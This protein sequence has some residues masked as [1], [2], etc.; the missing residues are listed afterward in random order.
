M[1]GWVGGG[2]MNLYLVR[3]DSLGDTLWTRTYGSDSVEF[4]GRSVQQT[5]DGGYFVVGYT[6]PGIHG[7]ADIPVWKFSPD[8]DIELEKVFGSF[9]H[10]VGNEVQQTTD[11]GYIIVGSTHLDPFQGSIYLI[12]TNSAGDSLWSRTLGLPYSAWGSSLQQTQKSWG[13]TFKLQY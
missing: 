1:T 2:T 13:Q 8:G 6:E 7:H 12:K 10:E 9:G 11:G 4:Q 3:T 5:E